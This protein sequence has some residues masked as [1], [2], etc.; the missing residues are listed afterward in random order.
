ME[1]VTRKNGGRYVPDNFK[2]A[3]DILQLVTRVL[4]VKDD[5]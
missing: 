2:E 4:H 3:I 5:A 1:T